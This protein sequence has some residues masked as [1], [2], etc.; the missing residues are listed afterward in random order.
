M[1]RYEEN[2]LKFENKRET[3]YLLGFPFFNL[4]H[5]NFVSI[6]MNLQFNCEESRGKCTLLFFLNVLIIIRLDISN[7]GA[8]CDFC[9]INRIIPVTNSFLIKTTPFRPYIL[10]I[11]AFSVRFTSN[12]LLK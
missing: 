7:A 11:L 1:Q 9:K 5:T 2:N 3:Q 8:I 6:I 4:F 10:Q 12:L